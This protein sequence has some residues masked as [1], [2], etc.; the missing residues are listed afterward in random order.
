MASTTKNGKLVHP[1]IAA[2]NIPIG[3][4]GE[5]S[6]WAFGWF[7]CLTP[8]QLLGPV[9]NLRIGGGIAV[10]HHDCGDRLAALATHTFICGWV[11]KTKKPVPPP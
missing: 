8:A 5:R 4:V 3:D 11:L 2:N 7:G 6:S 10:Q 9:P 1:I